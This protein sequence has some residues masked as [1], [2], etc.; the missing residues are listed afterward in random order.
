MQRNIIIKLIGCSIG[1]LL[2]VLHLLYGEDFVV[3]YIFWEILHFVGGAA[4]GMLFY[5]QERSLLSTL[6]LVVGIGLL[7]EIYEYYIR[8]IPFWFF[9]TIL[10]FILEILGACIV[11]IFLQKRS[12]LQ[13]AQETTNAN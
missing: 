11:I 4:L 6:L 8:N 13:K 3:P 10:D 9:D 1:L 2:I 7:W 12:V 5:N